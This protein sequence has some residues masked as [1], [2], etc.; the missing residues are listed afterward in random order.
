MEQNW[1]PS[2]WLTSIFPAQEKRCR[3]PVINTQPAAGNEQIL[4]AGDW[5][6]E[7]ETAEESTHKINLN[8]FLRCIL[9]VYIAYFMYYPKCPWSIMF[10]TVSGKSVHKVLYWENG[11]NIIICNEYN[12]AIFAMIVYFSCH[13]LLVPLLRL[14]LYYKKRHNSKHNFTYQGRNSHLV[15]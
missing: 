12:Q 6:T 11:W 14:F 15:K 7:F 3:N 10:L 1:K 8:I 2:Q 9:L 5:E 4:G 13:W